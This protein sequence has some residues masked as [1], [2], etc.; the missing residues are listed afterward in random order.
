L[1]CCD[2][3]AIIIKIQSRQ[4]LP[5]VTKCCCRCACCYSTSSRSASSSFS[6]YS[7]RQQV[8]CKRFDNLDRMFVRPFVVVLLLL[9]LLFRLFSLQI[10]KNDLFYLF[11]KVAEQ[12]QQQQLLNFIDC[13]HSINN[14]F[15]AIYSLKFS[16]ISFISFFSHPRVHVIV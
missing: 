5:D 9:L 11:A 7:G 3:H 8:Q 2:N 6:I 16:L 10:M 14:R 4:S 1:S 13:L 15:S 12:Q